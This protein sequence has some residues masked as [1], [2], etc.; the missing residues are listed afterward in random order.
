MVKTPPVRQP[1]IHTLKPAVM[2]HN[3][4]QG[5]STRR[6]A[7]IDLLT[8]RVFAPGS[9]QYCRI[10][11]RQIGGQRYRL[12]IADRGTQAMAAV[13][14][15]LDEYGESHQ[16]A[17]NKALHWICVPLIVL[18]LIGILWSIPVP[19]V[20]SNISPLMNYGVIFLF[21]SLTYYFIM[22]V[23]LAIGM[24][25]FTA[26]VIAVTNWLDGFS[27]PLWMISL[28]I[29]VVAWIGQFIGHMIEGK[30]P[31]F[32]KD[33]QFLMIGPLWLLSAVYKKFGIPI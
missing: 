18:S 2:Q 19:E 22:S 13:E 9:R 4:S 21:A 11:L 1:A 17:T 24:V 32:F 7:G 27:T 26:A 16:N 31:S 8:N 33:V 5:P 23:P 20:F 15:W 14:T 6:P 12:Q 28:G 3:D 30:R 29:F 25:F 10:G